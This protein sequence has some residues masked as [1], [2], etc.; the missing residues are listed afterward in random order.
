MNRNL[1]IL[2]GL[3]LFLALPLRSQSIEVEPKVRS[4]AKAKTLII[5][6]INFK[7]VGLAD[8][9]AFFQDQS[10]ALDPDKKGLNFVLKSPKDP[11]A[12]E[13]TLSLNLKKIPLSE[14]LKYVSALTNYQLKYEDN[15]IL[16]L[17]P[18]RIKK[19]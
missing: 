9:I 17:P 10:A 3:F 11:G 13:P 2:A 6:E 16:L 12:A 19:P 18:E 4:Y 1:F 14:V 8:A 15:A 5:P 7:D